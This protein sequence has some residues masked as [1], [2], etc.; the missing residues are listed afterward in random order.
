MKLLLDTHLLLWAAGAPDRLSAEARSLID[1]PE[2]EL[3]YSVPVCG[4]SRLSA[5]WADVISRWT[6]GYCVA[7]CSIMAIASCRLSAI[8]L[9]P[10]RACR[11]FTRIRSI[12]CWW[13][14]RLWRVSRSLPSIL[15]S[16]SIPGPYGQCERNPRRAKASSANRG[17]TVRQWRGRVFAK[18]GLR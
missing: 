11:R 12:A 6:P 15:W 7:A 14:R 16:R 13:R 8:T 3:L 2:N 17:I 10:S 9:S 18:L 5:A 4:K 1:N